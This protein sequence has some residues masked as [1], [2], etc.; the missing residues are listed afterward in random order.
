MIFI[1]DSQPTALL[2]LEV[3]SFT[4]L[5]IRVSLRC[6]IYTKQALYTCSFHQIELKPKVLS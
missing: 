5:K 2:I 3:I 6:L 1:M 4:L